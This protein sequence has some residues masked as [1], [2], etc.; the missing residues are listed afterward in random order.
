MT[1]DELTRERLVADRM[2]KLEATI[3]AYDACLHT[4][5]VDSM[6]KRI[7]ALERALAGTLSEEG[8]SGKRKE[9]IEV[10][11]S[12]KLRQIY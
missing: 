10:L 2:R 6:R 3:R 12:T 1:A 9:E 5:G 7:D 11:L 4:G 8:M